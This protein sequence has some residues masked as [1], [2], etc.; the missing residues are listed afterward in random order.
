MV[1]SIWITFSIKFITKID[2]S[3]CII[4]KIFIFFCPRAVNAYNLRQTKLARICFYA[5]SL[6][7]VY[8]LSNT[9][10]GNLL[11]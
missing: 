10:T 9:C 4:A 5:I 11:F 3:G 7:F 6:N 8:I 1:L 2:F